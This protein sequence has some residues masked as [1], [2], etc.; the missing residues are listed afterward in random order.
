MTLEC[1]KCGEEFEYKPGKPGYR[2]ECPACA[3]DVPML[4]GNMVW[5]HKTAP[6]L[7]IKS[8]AQAR[9]YAKQTRRFGAGVTVCLT[10]AKYTDDERFAMRE[11]KA[12]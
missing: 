8:M 10:E 3:K 7:E 2:D 9:A 5:A 6:E 1:R 4:G 12:E 11:Q